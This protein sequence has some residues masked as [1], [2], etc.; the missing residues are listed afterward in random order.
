MTRK[1]SVVA[2][3]TLLVL[4]GSYFSFARQ[5]HAHAAACHDLLRHQREYR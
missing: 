5:V 3:F 1:Y 2:V 4:L